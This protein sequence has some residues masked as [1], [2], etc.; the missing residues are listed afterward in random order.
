[1]DEVITSERKLDMTRATLLSSK[2]QL[3]LVG[4]PPSLA[5]QL[6]KIFVGLGSNNFVFEK[7]RIENRIE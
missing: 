2:Q 1:M 5:H 3:C 4:G 6:S 7:I